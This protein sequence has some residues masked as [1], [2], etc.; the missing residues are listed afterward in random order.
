MFCNHRR[1]GGRGLMLAPPSTSLPFQSSS[2]HNWGEAR[3]TTA[4]VNK[5]ARGDPDLNMTEGELAVANWSSHSFRRGA[6]KQ[7][8]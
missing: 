2:H 8:R 7:A 3:L 6:D 1:T 4:A 5:A